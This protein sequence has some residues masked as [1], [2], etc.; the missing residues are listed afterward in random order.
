MRSRKAE[1]HSRVHAIPEL[2]FE[3]QDLTS[4]AG[5]VIFQPLLQRLELGSQL[6]KCFSHVRRQ[7]SYGLSTIFLL[8]VIHIT[9]GY[10]RLREMT[11]YKDDPMVLRVLGLR[12]MPEVAT[13]SRNLSAVDMKA[14]EG[15]GKV[16]RSLVLE[17]LVTDCSTRVTLDF[18][19]SV[20][21]TRRAAEGTAVGFNRKHKGDRSYYPLFC[22]VAQTGQVL[23]LLHR[24]GNV[25]DSHDA[26]GFIATCF[27]AVAEKVPGAVPESRLDSAFFSWETV[28]LLV[29]RGVGF[30]ISVPFERLPD[31]KKEV[32]SRRRWYQIDDVWS[33]FELGWAPKSWPCALRVLVVRQAVSIK[34]KGPLQLDFFEP[35][36]W[37]YEYTVIA[38]NKTVSPRHILAF[39]HGRGSQ[40]GIFS[41]L[42]SHAQMDYIPTRRWAGNRLYLQAAVIAHN[43]TREMQMSVLGP[44]HRNT[45]NRAALWTFE[46]LGT[47]RNTLIRRAGRLTRPAGRLVLS[48]S[49]NAAAQEAI[50]RYLAIAA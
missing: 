25:H 29:G 24:S 26:H 27:D 28:N 21:S 1:I 35:R 48:M 3:D 13:V 9:L 49:R 37:Q 34:T 43:I 42:K 7:G 6:R 39:H 11:F 47:I 18:D 45:P 2:R 8:L 31:L 17:R 10:R 4:F 38:T 23:D 41:Q 44:E 33:Y 16:S 15:V 14:C 32:E 20:C 50:T 30:S 46:R 40:E 5:L 22:T 19:G 12:R 36:E